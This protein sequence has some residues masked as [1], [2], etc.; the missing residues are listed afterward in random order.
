MS[1]CLI[2]CCELIYILYIYSYFIPLLFYMLLA[3]LRPAFLFFPSGARS[4]PFPVWFSKRRNLSW[5][6]NSK[7]SLRYY[8]VIHVKYNSIRCRQF[9]SLYEHSILHVFQRRMTILCT[10]HQCDL[11]NRESLR[12]NTS[13]SIL[14]FQSICRFTS[15]R[16]ITYK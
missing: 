1:G 5:N 10:K 16:I 6:I 13:S 7:L 3:A 14:G 15:E 11:R 8:L 2:G 12:N 9:F 4:A